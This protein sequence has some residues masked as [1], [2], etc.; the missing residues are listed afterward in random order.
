MYVLGILAR[1][2]LELSHGQRAHKL[3][4]ALD[5]LLLNLAT[6]ADHALRG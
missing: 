6:S 4:E 2:R 3:R 5:E 1:G